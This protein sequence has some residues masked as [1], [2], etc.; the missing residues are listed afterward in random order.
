MNKQ[1]ISDWIYL[2]DILEQNEEK[3]SI[4]QVYH[5]LKNQEIDLLK[6]K[7]LTPS[8][9]AKIIEK[10]GK[11]FWY[12]FILG[13]I[14]DDKNLIW[15]SRLENIQNIILSRDDLELKDINRFEKNHRTIGW[16]ALRAAVLWWNDWLVSNLSLIMWVAWA[17]LWQKEII[18]TWI[19]WV[20][21]WWLSMA[22]W[23]WISV[24]SSQELSENQMKLEKQAIENNPEAEKHEIMI[25]YMSKWIEKSQAEKIANDIMKDKKKVF[26]I[27][28]QDE[29]KIDP[30][31]LKGSAMQA[32]VASFCLFCIGALIPIF[33][34]FFL[35]WNNAIIASLIF[36]WIGLFGIWSAITLFT[37]KKVIFSWTRQLIFWLLAAAITF[38]IWK[39]IWVSVAG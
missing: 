38:G 9:Q 5:T 17:A 8:I 22:L 25:M 13:K 7:V 32:A 20:L 30:D 6:W 39:I 21:A 11:I 23:E 28:V 16:N 18:L 27:M 35:K 15:Y 37:G 19:A 26:E 33:P 24:K 34:F 1:K 4:R 31:E 3:E 36:S 10:T 12:D 29:L 2:L 14:L